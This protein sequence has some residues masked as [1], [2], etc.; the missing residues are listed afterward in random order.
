MNALLI[1]CAAGLVSL[2]AAVQPDRT[3]PAQP[4]PS[5]QPPDRPLD[6]EPSQDDRARLAQPGPEHRNLSAFVGSWDVSGQMWMEPGASPETVSGT[7]TARW[8]L[9]NRFV[10]SHAEGSYGGKPYEGFGVMGYDNAQ[11]K[12]VSSWQDNMCTSLKSAKGEYDAASKTFTFKGESKDEKGLNV[13]TRCTVKV[14]S[15]NEHTETMFVTAPGQK[16]AKVMEITFR[17]SGSEPARKD[18][19]KPSTP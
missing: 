10:Q 13:L 3:R 6:K 18:E 17:R 14:T 2:S 12:Y 19:K 5:K 15:D 9:D 11:K 8:V 7:C 4:T 16:E 1:A